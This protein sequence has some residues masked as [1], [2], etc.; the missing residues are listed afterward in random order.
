MNQPAL[1]STGDKP[2][3]NAYIHA[4]RK[5]A[6]DF[7]HFNRV[8]VRCYSINLMLGTVQSTSWPTVC[9][10]NTHSLAHIKRSS[11]DESA[12]NR[13]RGFQRRR[14]SAHLFIELHLLQRRLEHGSIASVLFWRCCSNIE[15]S[16]LA[17]QNPA[18]HV[19]FV[20]GF[21]VGRTARVR[22]DARIRTLAAT[23]S[24][25]VNSIC[26]GLWCHIIWIGW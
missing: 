10:V 19:Y 6:F 15:V 7:L 23:D 13:D 11:F 4:S 26:C 1:Q 24:G 12:S 5:P 3:Q 21:N 2:C 8:C 18:Y 14:L 9:E 17:L 20:G 16:N 25:T 22:L